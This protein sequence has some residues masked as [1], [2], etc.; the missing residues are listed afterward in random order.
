MNY[1]QRIYLDTLDIK[2]ILM[3][4]SLSLLLEQIAKYSETK[5]NCYTKNKNKV[6]VE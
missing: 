1:K 6:N 3:L 5:I 4:L 2:F